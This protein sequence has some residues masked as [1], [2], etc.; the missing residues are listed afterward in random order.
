MVAPTLFSNFTHHKYDM[1]SATQCECPDFDAPGNIPPESPRLSVRNG[2]LLLCIV[3]PTPFSH[4]SSP[5]YEVGI[6]MGCHIVI[7]LFVQICVLLYM[8]V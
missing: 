5:N 2:A 6:H 8:A 4:F 1:G 7:L 3:A